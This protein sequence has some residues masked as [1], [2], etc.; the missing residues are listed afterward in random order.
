MSISCGVQC[1][2]SHNSGQNEWYTPES[3]ISLVYNVMG[4]IDI[5]VA[6]SDIANQTVKAKKYFTKES[7]G[8]SQKWYGNIFMNPPYSVKLIQQFAEK[9]VNE[10]KNIDQAVV[11]VN[12]A[13]E[14]K[15]FKSISSIANAVCFPTGRM[16]FYAP[17]GKTA[18][19]LQGQAILYIGDNTQSFLDN[20]SSIGWCAI[21]Q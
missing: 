1:H 21:I 4:N 7:D 18:N 17:D 9:L 12:N 13:T 15:W 3:I 5:D 10:R 6:S 16:R 11:L 14:T 2:V 19:P 8:L 20:F